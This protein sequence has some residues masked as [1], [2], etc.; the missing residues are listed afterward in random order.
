MKTRKLFV[1]YIVLLFAISIGAAHAVN[2]N[3]TSDDLTIQKDLPVKSSIEQDEIKENETENF[4]QLSELIENTSENGT[5]ELDKDYAANETEFIS[6]SKPMTVDGKGHTL[7]ANNM[8][9]IFSVNVSNVILKNIVFKNTNSYAI[10]A[11][12]DN[13]TVDNCSFINCSA[14]FDLYYENY[15]IIRIDC[16]DLCVFN[17]CRFINCTGNEIYFSESNKNTITNTEFINCISSFKGSAIYFLREC[18]DN[19]ICICSFINCSAYWNGG[20]IYFDNDTTVPYGDYDIPLHYPGSNNCTVRDCYFMN[21]NADKGGS[22]YWGGLDGKLENSI[23]NGN[24]AEDGGAVYW[25]GKNGEITD[26]TFTKNKASNCGGAVYGFNKTNLKVVNSTFENNTATKYGGAIYGGNITNCS[27]IKNSVPE[28]YTPSY[29]TSSITIKN[30]KIVYNS[31]QKCTIT[32][33]KDKEIPG[34]G[35]KVVIKLNGKIIKTTKTNPKGIVELKITQKP[36]T[37]KL[38]IISLNKTVSKILTVQHL[39]TL[40]SVN[41]KKSAKKL[42]LQATLKKVNG[43]YLKNKKITFKFNGKKYTAKT[44]KKGVAKVTV[45]KTTLKKL[46]IGKKITYAA[47]YLKDTVKKTVKV[48]R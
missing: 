20:A 5:L 21:C 48:K 38:T 44:N 2:D 3:M 26:S 14:E 41:V 7:D 29:S 36:G 34:N 17:N 18:R 39:I 16:A 4:F 46:K 47:T 23:F 28:T 24:T 22:I 35:A 45:K 30:T 10:Y 13:L 31:N 11:N 33:Y 43:K 6:I 9:G 37:Y 12:F 8:S 15:G 42:T 1:V 19:I 25:C 32:V 40:K 27:F